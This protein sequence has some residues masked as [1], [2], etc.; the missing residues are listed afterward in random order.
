MNRKQLITKTLIIGL[1]LIS[2]GGWFLHHAIHPL[3]RG[4]VYYIPYLVGL[5]SALIIPVLFCFRR[6]LNLAYILNGLAVILG[7]I[8]MIQFSR[9]MFPDVAILW[10][11]F[12]LGYALYR[13]ITMR[14]DEDVVPSGRFIRYPNM[15]WWWVHLVGL[16]AVYYLGNVLWK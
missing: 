5:V 13:N 16:S 7:T 12:A 15:G 14:S 11:K 8:T 10:C 3:S 2:F 6:T 1:F 9:T 4:H